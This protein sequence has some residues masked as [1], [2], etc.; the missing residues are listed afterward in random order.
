MITAEDVQFH[1]PDKVKYDWAE[2]MFFSVYLQEPNI[3]AWVYTVARPGV[4]AMVCDIEAFDRIGNTRLDAL[5]YDFQQHLPI[6]DKLQSY[7][8]PN[9]LSLETSNEPR[10]YHVRY[11]G[12]GDTEFDWHV[13]GIME[14]YDILDPSMDPLATGNPKDSGFGEA[15]ANHF[16]MTAHVTGTLKIRGR[17]FPV[18][19]VTV[20]DHSWGPRNERLLGN[21]GWINANFGED[22]SIATIWSKDLSQTGWDEYSFAH[23]YALIDGRVRGLKSGR[24]RATRNRFLMPVS[25]EMRVVDVDDREH[26]LFGSPV[27][28]LPWACYTNLYVPH[29]TVR[30]HAGNREGYGQAQESYPLDRLTSGPFEPRNES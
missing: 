6:P 26:V 16:D 12:N 23:G 29:S 5:Y 22:Y 10:D 19:C 9:G 4:G 27:G 30:W 25:Y 2:T 24:L 1:T 20:M 28:Q 3:T 18:D 17:T 13:R 11:I 7:S 15:Y 14:P 21:M 8:L